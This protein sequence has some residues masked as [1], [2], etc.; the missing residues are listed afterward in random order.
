MTILVP[1]PAQA[2]E[3]HLTGLSSDELARVLEVSQSL[4]GSL[5]VDQ[6][7]GKVARAAR[8]VLATDMSTVLILDEERQL[9]TV[10]A[11]DGVD[12]D[13][14]RRLSTPVG[15]NLAGLAAQLGQCVSTR[16]IACDDRSTLAGI[17]EGHIRSVMLAPLM[18]DGRVLGVIGVETRSEREFSERDERMLRLLANHGAI[19]IDTA[20]LYGVEHD[21]VEQLNDLLVRLNA[22]NDVMHR[23]REAHMRLS[24]AA[25]EGLGYASILEI[26]V[27]LVPVPIVLTNQFGARLS[28]AAPAQDE[29]LEELWGRCA[30]TAGFTRQL[31]RLRANA[32]LAQPARVGEAGFWRAVVVGAAAELL[33]TLVILDHSGLEELHMVVLEQAANVIATELL[34]ERSVAEAEARASGDLVRLLVSSGGW[35]EEAQERAALLGHDLTGGQCVVAVDVQPRAAMREAQALVSVTRRAASRAGLRCL[36]GECAGVLVVLLADGDRA[37]CR[38]SVEAWVESFRQEAEARTPGRLSFGV[39]SIGLEPPDIKDGFG[40]ARQALAVCRL[41]AQRHLACFEDVQLIATLID[42]TNRE[43]VECYI[44]QAIGALRDYDRRKNT[45]LAHT[46]DVYLDCSG[47]ARHAAKALF[48]H[49]HSLRY[50]LRRIG[51]IQSLDL[52]DPMSRLTAHLALKLQ[53]MISEPA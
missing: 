53:A 43:A 46:L 25:L 31:E 16:D 34:R 6:V 7:L 36:A 41:D 18:R 3:N 13:V 32:G 27:E 15:E 24:E 4:G 14:A 44:E 29:R 17:C 30:G 38:G 20:R 49:P 35:G 21:R 11:F 51:E 10:A 28:A 5:D 12:P 37:L 26:L 8:E 23:A 50:R 22:Q 19:A 45:E 2:A 33:G 39:S 48:V 52:S 40:A 1:A 47:V 9:L 42:I